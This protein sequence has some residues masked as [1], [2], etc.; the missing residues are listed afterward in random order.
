MAKE[1]IM[2]RFG[3]NRIRLADMLHDISRPPAAGYD[4]DAARQGG[5]ALVVYLYSIGLDESH[6]L[7]MVLH[8]P[9]A[10]S[11]S[12]T[13]VAELMTLYSQLYPAA[14]AEIVRQ[15]F[16]TPLRA[17]TE[18]QP[19]YD[20]GA[21]EASPRQRKTGLTDGIGHKETKAPI[22]GRRVSRSE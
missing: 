5:E 6:T 21:A 4:T 19:I 13:K 3:D 22:F 15:L 17:T 2:A 11:H 14:A 18:H 8:G 20:N 1:L 10:V 12:Y 9:D 7:S 16:G